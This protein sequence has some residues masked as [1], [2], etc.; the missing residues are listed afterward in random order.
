MRPGAYVATSA[1]E[2]LRAGERYGLRVA[3]FNA[4]T[5][6]APVFCRET[7]ALLWGLW[8][9]GMPPKVH[10]AMDYRGGRSWNDIRVHAGDESM[11]LVQFGGLLATDKLRTTLELISTLPFMYAVAVCDSAQRPPGR[12][13]LPVEPG[14]D[15]EPRWTHDEP[16]GAPLSVEELEAGAAGLPSQAK[17]NRALGIIGLSSPLSGSAGESLSRAKMHVAGFSAPE[18]QHPFNLRDGSTALVDFWFPALRIAG[19]FDGEGKYLRS[20]WGKGLDVAQRV[21]AEKK[22][23]NAIRAQRV[24]FARWDWKELM[25]PGVLESILREAGLRPELRRRTS[26]QK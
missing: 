7:A 17:R 10:I 19:E 21:L 3:A 4:T 14:P 1:W 12:G 6:S 15:T 13:K 5:S 25:A 23:E 26:L 20:D 16:M 18:L 2:A 24:T 8:T 11:G 9:V 22:R